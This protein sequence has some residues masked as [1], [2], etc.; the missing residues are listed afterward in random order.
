[1]N[2][3]GNNGCLQQQLCCYFLQLPDH[4]KWLSLVYVFKMKLVML[5]SRCIYRWK[6]FQYH[7]SLQSL[8]VIILLRILVSVSLVMPR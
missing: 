1:L 5:R 2:R 7:S 4:Y 3:A 6:L 8:K